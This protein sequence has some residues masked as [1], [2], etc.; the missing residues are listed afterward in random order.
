MGFILSKSMDANLTKQQEFMLHNSRLQVSC[1]VVSMGFILSK[2]MDANLTKQQEF[3]LH[4]SRLQVSCNVVSMGFILSKSMDAN[5][6]K[7]QEFMLHNSRLQYTVFLILHDL[8]PSRNC[9]PLMSG[10]KAWRPSSGRSLET[11]TRSV[12]QHCHDGNKCNLGILLT[13]QFLH[14]HMR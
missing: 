5:L 3:M 13:R 11:R 14:E 2:S 7:Q 6:T 10:G 9:L 1:N 12:F 8:G 4:N